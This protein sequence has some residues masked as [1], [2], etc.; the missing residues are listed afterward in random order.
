MLIASAKFE[1]F[2]DINDFIYC[3]QELH[4]SSVEGKIVPFCV[5]LLRKKKKKHKEESYSNR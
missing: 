3:I 2:N 5:K 1:S 4:Q